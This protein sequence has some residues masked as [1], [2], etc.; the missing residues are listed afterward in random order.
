MKKGQGV[1]ELSW[2]QRQITT[3]AA[4]QG[5]S[6]FVYIEFRALK[7]FIIEGLGLGV[8]GP[9]HPGHV[10]QGI[11]KQQEPRC[12]ASWLEGAWEGSSL[13]LFSGYCFCWVH[14]LAFAFQSLPGVAQSL[15]PT[16]ECRSAQPQSISTKRGWDVRGKIILC[17]RFFVLGVGRG[18]GGGV[19]GFVVELALDLDL[20]LASSNFPQDQRGTL[21]P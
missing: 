15:P 18:G 6:L 20:S 9:E 4:V 12:F 2:A 7:G 21:L 10:F 5:L 14:L 3:R 19:V 17:F 13:F 11:Y 16:P 1:Q 8:E